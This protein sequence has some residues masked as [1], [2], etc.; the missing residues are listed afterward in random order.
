MVS[1]ATILPLN[2]IDL[3]I[4]SG[5]AF[6]IIGI[7]KIEFLPLDWIYRS[8]RI[9]TVFSRIDDLQVISTMRLVGSALRE[10]VI[11]IR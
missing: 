5:A 6:H 3:K 9:M 2:W 4:F 10:W 8:I 11:V 1:T 7:T